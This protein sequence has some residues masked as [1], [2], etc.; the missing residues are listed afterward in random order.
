MSPHQIDHGGEQAL[1][2]GAVTKS[3]T[4]LFDLP[5]VMMLP[6][7]GGPTTDLRAYIARELILESAAFLREGKALS[8]E[9]TKERAGS[10]STH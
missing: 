8:H 7:Q 5:N 10:M 2:K 4:T 1:S 3:D 9:I 6:H